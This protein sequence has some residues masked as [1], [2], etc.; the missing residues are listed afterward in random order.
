MNGVRAFVR[1]QDGKISDI[2]AALALV[3]A[4]A[5]SHRSSGQD[6]DGDSA[7]EGSGG[8]GAAGKASSGASIL[9]DFTFAKGSEHKRYLG[10]GAFSFSSPEELT[11]AVR[12][13]S[14][15]SSSSA[16]NRF[17]K[18]DPLRLP[19]SSSGARS[20]S[21]AVHMVGLED[22][23]P[24]IGLPSGIGDLSGEDSS[25]EVAAAEGEAR[26]LS[27]GEWLDYKIERR[28]SE[29]IPRMQPADEPSQ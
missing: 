23:A 29:P 3:R 26:R 1:A 7:G 4:V 13:Q 18:P 19:P 12:R 8:G 14:S 22:V 10:Y 6:V 20:P 5:F 16:R 15:T 21:S 2:H 28:T 9:R 27:A 24:L 25:S 11:S 17:F